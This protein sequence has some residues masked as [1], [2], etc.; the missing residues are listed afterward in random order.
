[1]VR[2]LVTGSRDW[3]DR[4]QIARAIQRVIILTCPMLVDENGN[5]DRR[6]TSDVVIVHGDCPTGAD[7]LAEQWATGCQP[8]IKT[9]PHPADW[10]LYDKAAGFIRNKEMADLGAVACLAF[11]N[12]CRKEDCK[13]VGL[14]G[15]HGATHCAHQ[16]ELRNIPVVRYPTKK[17]T[18]T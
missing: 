2:I 13:N 15:S 11:I 10:D 4:V 9:E 3:T 5:P 18:S 8:P 12:P 6:D 14:H 16:A 1:M 17:G 7:R